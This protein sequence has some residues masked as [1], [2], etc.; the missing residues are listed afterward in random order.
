MDNDELYDLT[1]E[2]VE[3]FSNGVDWEGFEK[4]KQAI[5]EQNEVYG[6]GD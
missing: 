3:E 4:F 6:Y 1:D 2:A 5:E